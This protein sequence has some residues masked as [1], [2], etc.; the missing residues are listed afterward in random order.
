MKE[1][2]GRPQTT[3]ILQ[4][5]LEN[6]LLHMG[7][8]KAFTR[9]SLQKQFKKQQNAHVGSNDPQSWGTEKKLPAE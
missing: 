6:N 3:K 9:L 2:N 7:F 5:N 4:E 1:F 8:P